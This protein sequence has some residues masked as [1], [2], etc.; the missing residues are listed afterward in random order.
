MRSDLLN[1]E[2][3]AHIIVPHVARIHR[4]VVTDAN[5]RVLAKVLPSW[6][7]CLQRLLLLKG[8]PSLRI[9]CQLEVVCVVKAMAQIFFYFLFY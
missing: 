1:L 7:L 6:M 5:A 9:K 3:F 2:V 4:F 8:G